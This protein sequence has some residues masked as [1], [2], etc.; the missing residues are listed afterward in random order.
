MGK[1]TDWASACARE[2]SGF[3]AVNEAVPELVVVC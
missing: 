1:G 2:G 3:H